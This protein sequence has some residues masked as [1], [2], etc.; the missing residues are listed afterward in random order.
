MPISFICAVVPPLISGLLKG[1]AKQKQ[2]KYIEVVF[3]EENPRT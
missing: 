3:F 1:A 2:T